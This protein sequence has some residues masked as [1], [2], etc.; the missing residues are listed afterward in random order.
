MRLQSLDALGF[1]GSYVREDGYIF[2]HKGKMLAAY[3]NG[4]V[5]LSVGEG[6]G[7]RWLSV[8]KAVAWAFVPNQYAYTNVRRKNGKLEDN[9]AEN[10][11]WVP[12]HSPARDL[13]VNYYVQGKTVKEIS[14]L[15]GSTT[16]YVKKTLEVYRAQQPD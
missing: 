10:L 7:K 4:S 15:S 14:I 16:T 12:R 13:I 5:H 9:R 11:E 3:P 8:H 2:D 1:F 6:M